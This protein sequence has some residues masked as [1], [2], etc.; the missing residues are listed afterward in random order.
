VKRG[1]HKDTYLIRHSADYRVIASI[2]GPEAIIDAEGGGPCV[3]VHDLHWTLYVR[4]IQGERC[5]VAIQRQRR[6]ERLR[7]E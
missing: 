2:E 3:S 6:L 7:S 5:Y 1:V 4:V